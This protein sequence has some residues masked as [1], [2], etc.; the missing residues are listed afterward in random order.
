MKEI[1]KEMLF[2][3]QF[4]TNLKKP[5]K[6]IINVEGKVH[7]TISQ[8]ILGKNGFGYDPIFIPKKS[9]INFWTN[10]KKKKN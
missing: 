10:V 1:E 8:K 7:G 5:N 2:C 3:L 6:K 9:K 4:I